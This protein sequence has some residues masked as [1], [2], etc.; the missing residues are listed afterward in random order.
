MWVYRAANSHNSSSRL[1]EGLLL[2]CVLTVATTGTFQE[3]VP[4]FTPRVLVSIRKISQDP[5]VVVMVEEVGIMVDAGAVDT[6]QSSG[7]G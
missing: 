5:A 7:D 2:A 6:A 3:V 1:C 4:S